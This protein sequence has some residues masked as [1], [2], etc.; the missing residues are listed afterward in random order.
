MPMMAAA[1]VGA[2]VVGG[3]MGSMSA[4]KGRKQAAAASAAAFQE[5]LNIGLPPDLS[6]EIILKQF[7]SEGILTPEL[8]QDIN[9]QESQ[10]G[11]IKEDASL[12]GVQKE[13]LD[14]LGQVSRSGLRAEDRGA[15]NELRAKTQ[16]DS[17]AKRQQILQQM[18]A[19]G[20]GSSGANLMAQLQ[21]AQAAEDSQSAGADRL[22]SEAS[23]R[24]LDA[25]SQRAQLAGGVRT[26]DF[27][28]NEARAKA[29]DDRNQF[30][31]A[32]SASRQSANVA[33]QNQAQQANLSNKQRIGDLN[34]GQANTE[35]LRQNQAKRDYWQDNLSLAQA[36]S[37]A[38]TSQGQQA[39]AAGQAQ[40]DR[41]VGMGNSI[42]QGVA[43]YGQQTN[44]NDQRAADR[45]AGVG[46]K[47]V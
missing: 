16:Q 14:T 13:A 8:E 29:L 5:L 44:E 11:Q 10:V 45:R 7:K 19:Q 42:G 22:A 18:Q 43:A 9:I 1:V 24:A 30:L 32:N 37:A 6:K 41:Y 27:G 31:Y 28:V 39:Q 26:Q 46:T 12:R 20:M 2:S 35:S 36:K 34:V 3:I 17:E 38:L 47:R 40:A 21:S 23:R 15:F 4:S 25:V 33:A